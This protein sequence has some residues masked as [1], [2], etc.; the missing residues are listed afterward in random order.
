[1]SQDAV[2]PEQ[3]ATSRIPLHK[4]WWFRVGG[5]VSILGLLALAL[6][7]D[8]LFESLRQVPV[9]VG[10]AALGIYLC[11]HMIGT[12]KWRMMLGAA[13]AQLSLREAMTCYY[14]GLFGNTFLPSVVG[15]DVVRAGLATRMSRSTAGVVLGRRGRPDDR[16]DRFGLRSRSRYRASPYSS[17]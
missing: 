14:A 8:V 17:R 6:P 2:G 5:S 15:G 7:L 4:R 3:A 13:G 11:L 9:W 1:M 10:L 12:L 16:H